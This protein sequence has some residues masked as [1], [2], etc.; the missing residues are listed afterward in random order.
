MTRK[1]QNKIL[2]DKIK[3]N[4]AQYNLDR[5]NAEI[6]AYS[7]GDLPKCEY[8]TKK[9]LNYKPNAFEQAKFEYSPLGKVFIDGLDKFDEKEGL[10]KRL[11]NIE[12][13]S[14][15]QLLALKNINKLAIRGKDDGSDDD[16]GDDDDDDDDN[17]YKRIVN[18][19]KNNKIDYKNIEKELNKINKRID[20]YEKTKKTLEKIP[21]YKNQVDKD[22]KDAD[23]L[24]RII[25]EIILNKIIKKHTIKKVFDISWIDNTELFNKI[26]NDFTSRYNKNKDS[27]ELLL[28]Q[29]FLDNISNEH[30]KN[31]KDAREEL[32]KLK[33]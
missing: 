22:K 2:D 11:K 12:N 14:N 6:S 10:L 29:N 1:E 31:K 18:D 26:S 16:D 3:A 23:M 19:Y 17:N 7:S 24:K 13:K 20:F 15:N 8:L 5:M 28:I 21:M 27:F 25:N 30:I 4:N 9:D 32:K 33:K